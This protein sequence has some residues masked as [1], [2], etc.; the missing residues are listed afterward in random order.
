M[1]RQIYEGWLEN[2]NMRNPLLIHIISQLADDAA[3]VW[4]EQARSVGLGG[5]A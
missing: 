2:L 5:D 4:C 1:A 3:L